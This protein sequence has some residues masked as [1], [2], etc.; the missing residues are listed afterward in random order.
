MSARRTHASRV[1]IDIETS[2]LKMPRSE[3]RASLA[4]V[5][6]KGV[7]IDQ[8]AIDEA[9]KYEAVFFGADYAAIEQR[10]YTELTYMRTTG[11]GAESIARYAK[12]HFG[13]EHTV[14]YAQDLIAKYNQEFLA[15]FLGAP[16]GVDGTCHTGRSTC[17]QP[18][19][20][21]LRPRAP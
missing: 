5:V 20:Q 8:V 13:I 15:S 16:A 21:R 6:L 4:P 2:P 9:L 19:V 1:A 10:L 7:K 14:E 12:Q 3:R 18:A 17:S 11:L